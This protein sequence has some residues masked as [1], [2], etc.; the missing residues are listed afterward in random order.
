MINFQF[1]TDF[2]ALILGADLIL[3]VSDINGI[4]QLPVFQKGVDYQF[5]YHKLFMDNEMKL[6]NYDQLL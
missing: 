4:P 5:E 6:Q 3:V 2:S 1:L